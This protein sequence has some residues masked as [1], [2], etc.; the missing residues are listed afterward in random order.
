MWYSYRFFQKRGIKT[1]K[2]RFFYGNYKQIEE[3]VCPLKSYVYDWIYK[4]KMSFFFLA[5]LKHFTQVDQRTRHKNI[6]VL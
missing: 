1:P 5:I 4:F 2:Y 6:W 3:E